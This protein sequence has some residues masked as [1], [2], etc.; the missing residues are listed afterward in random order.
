MNIGY[1]TVAGATVYL[2]DKSRE[3][4]PELRSLLRSWSQALSEGFTEKE[5][6]SAVTTLRIMNENAKTAVASLKPDPPSP[7]GIGT[8]PPQL[9]EHAAL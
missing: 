9:A 1:V 4:A 3:A 2:T 6:Q 7:L 5:T 8:A